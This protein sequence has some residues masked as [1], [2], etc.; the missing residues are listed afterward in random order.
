MWS[1]VVSGRA[2]VLAEH[3][4][5]RLALQAECSQRLWS[6]P[7]PGESV[8]SFSAE[9]PASMM[10]QM[11]RGSVAAK[12]DANPVISHS[13]R[14]LSPFRMGLTGEA[15]DESVA[16]IDDFPSNREWFEDPEWIA[17]LADSLPFKKVFQYHFRRT[18]HINVLESR[19][20]ASWTKHCAKQHFTSRIVGLLD[21]RVTLGAAAIVD[22]AA[23]A[24]PV[25]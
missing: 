7:N 12:H 1:V 11:A 18:A 2:T 24:F 3:P 16:S 17:E 5:V 9:Y 21:S 25:F 4:G 20:Y 8:A 6:L 19:M 15:P 14:E 10:R 13:A 23:I 22:P